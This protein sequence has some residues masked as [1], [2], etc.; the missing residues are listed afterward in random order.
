LR[1]TILFA[2]R[3]KNDLNKSCSVFKDASNDVYML[4]W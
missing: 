3:W 2:V 1:L 4:C